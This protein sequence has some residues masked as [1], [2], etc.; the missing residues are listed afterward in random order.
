M[1]IQ[2][3]N[4]LQN[5]IDIAYL[6]SYSNEYLVQSLANLGQR[7]GIKGDSIQYNSFTFTDIYNNIDVSGYD[8]DKYIGVIIYSKTNND[9]IVSNFGICKKDTN[10]IINEKNI[11]S[12]IEKNSHIILNNA[13][14]KQFINNSVVLD[15]NINNISKYKYSSFY[16]SNKSFNNVLYGNILNTEE[17]ASNNIEIMFNKY[18]TSTGIL[19]YCVRA[20]HL[21][22]IGESNYYCMMVL[23]PIEHTINKYKLSFYIFNSSLLSSKIIKDEFESCFSYGKLN[24]NNQFFINVNDINNFDDLFM[25]RDET[26]CTLFGLI[27]HH[28]LNAELNGST[29]NIINIDLSSDSNVYFTLSD[30]NHN[31]NIIYVNELLS[32]VNSNILNRIQ[33]LNNDIIYLYSN[34]LELYS[35]NIFSN[36]VSSMYQF[37]LMKIYEYLY[38]NESDNNFSVIYV[39]LDYKFKYYANSNNSINI[40]NSLDIYM[41]LSNLN[42]LT[43]KELTNY[44]SS[45]KNITYVYNGVDK[46]IN[47]NYVIEY[48]KKYYKYPLDLSI[49]KIYTL[50][51]INQNNNWTINDNNSQISALGKNAGNPNIIILY[52][53]KDKENDEIKHKIIC[54]YDISNIQSTLEYND[55][56]FVID[57]NMLKH[58]INNDHIECSAKLPKITKGSVDFLSDSIIFLIS[59]QNCIIGDAIINDSNE[60]NYFATIWMVTPLPNDINNNTG[61]SQFDCITKSFVGGNNTYAFDISSLLNINNIIANVSNNMLKTEISFD[62]IFL[63]TISDELKQTEPERQ[64]IKG[65]IQN[66]D[67]NYYINNIRTNVLNNTSNEIILNNLTKYKNSLSLSIKYNNNVTFDDNKYTYI[68]GSTEKKYIEYDPNASYFTNS[69]ASSLYPLLMD[70]NNFVTNE[71]ITY[72]NEYNWE[73]NDKTTSITK[74]ISDFEVRESINSLVTSYITEKNPLFNVIPNE[75]IDY[76]YIYSADY[77]IGNKLDY[78]HNEY[79]FSGDV[80]LLDL[81]EI[82][83][84]NNNVLNRCNILTL[85]KT[86]ENSYACNIYNSYIGSSFDIGSDKSHLVIG[87]S[88]TNINIGTETLMAS[89]D[90]LHFKEQEVLDVNF[91]EINLNGNVNLPHGYLKTFNK[92]NT[93]YYVYE[94][95]GLCDLGLNINVYDTIGIDITTFSTFLNNEE[96]LIKNINI[97]N[98]NDIYNAI[99]NANNNIIDDNK[100]ILKYN[101]SN[102]DVC[103][104]VNTEIF[105]LSICPLE[106]SDAKFALTGK[107]YDKYLN[108]MY[109][110]FINLNKILDNILKNIFSETLEQL[111]KNNNINIYQKVSSINNPT[112][113]YKNNVITDGNIYL[114]ELLCNNMGSMSFVVDDND[115]LLTQKNILLYDKLKFIIY[116]DTKSTNDSGNTYNIEILGNKLPVF[117]SI[118]NN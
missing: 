98:V 57:P 17:N 28:N 26:D 73:F 38:N 75:F 50:P 88:K 14:S 71:I 24:E 59:N 47:I 70:A 63:N 107:E 20:F 29:D 39:P 100:F 41:S 77:K 117:S 113:T 95:D 11:S 23:E 21:Y 79:V 10:Q 94:Y 60:L 25:Y 69:V 78:F 90:T 49:N 96:N 93:T 114:C 45:L 27:K 76:S 67:Y 31:E 5:P 53:Y 68:T 9:E 15:I 56:K 55:S 1:S 44:L 110:P 82:L 85:D 118:I 80:P 84:V 6:T 46:I 108:Y 54:P 99:Y 8:P 52:N 12:L 16:Y 2:N 19:E 105:R 18:N 102:N 37:I 40:Y 32:K 64:K 34:L 97:N 87:S 43:S 3:I 101:S 35:S 30:N 66:S 13:F 33:F 92:E 61:Y 103:S 36:N 115:K 104:S 91:K 109:V 106:K 4:V 62:K 86:N 51:Y 74:T 22:T 72:R 83:L 111:S 7:L 42:I 116:K 48:D 58:A 112:R 81:K 65:L 89:G